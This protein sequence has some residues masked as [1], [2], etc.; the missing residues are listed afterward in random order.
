MTSTESYEEIL[1]LV[2]RAEE[3][4]RRALGEEV[5]EEIRDVCQTREN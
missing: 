2:E 3:I 4:L 5:L 1:A